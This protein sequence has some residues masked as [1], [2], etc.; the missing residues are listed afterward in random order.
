MEMQETD[1]IRGDAI[2]DGGSSDVYKG[3]K[4]N[5]GQPIVVKVFKGWVMRDA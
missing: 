1:F 2:G 5:G 4:V 3:V